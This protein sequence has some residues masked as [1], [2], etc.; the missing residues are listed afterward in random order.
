MRGIPRNALK[1]RADFATLHEAA[2]RDELRPHE[3]AELRRQWQS[4]LAG[5]KAYQVDRVLAEGES[6][7]GDEPEFRV[8]EELDEATDE[9]TRTQYKL[10][11]TLCSRLCRLGFEVEEV[12]AALVELEGK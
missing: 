4:L 12:E 5:R 8:M 10:T 9:V 1:T 2:L 6:P 3:V 7:D 11:E